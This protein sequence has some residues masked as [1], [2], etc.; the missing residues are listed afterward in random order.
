MTIEQNVLLGPLTTFH[1]GGPARYLARVST[2][3]EITEAF[4]YAQEAGLP[5]FVLGGGSNVLVSDN[6]FNGLV[7]M[8]DMR[9]VTVIN[10]DDKQVVLRVASG[11]IW[12]DVV[13]YA[14][15]RGLWGIENLSYLPGKAG[16]LAV[17]NV[18][19][20]GQEAS[21]VIDLVEVFDTDDKGL[22]ILPHDDCMFSYRASRF[23]QEDERRFIILSTVLKLSKIASPNLSYGDLQKYFNDSKLEP[24]LINI[25]EAIISIRENKYP[26]PKEPVNGSAGSF[27]KGPLLTDEEFSNLIEN[28]RQAF[29]DETA[30]R[31]DAMRDRLKVPQGFKT[32]GAFLL[33][34][35]GLK[36]MQMGGAKINEK[37]PAVILNA[38]GT[39]TSSDVI[40]LFEQARKIVFDKTGVMLESEPELV[41]FEE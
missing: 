13:K 7:M 29:G 1:I 24:T 40:G 18:G 20:Y 5:V 19:A 31:L 38:T 33:D 26:Y 27:F 6:G 12:D 8:P 32:P 35:C 16:A 14:V 39:A 11:E 9:G 34:I 37:Q 30:N 28:I 21:Q 25:R 17:Q 36:G 23:N 10:E 2:V 4:A 3:A 22:K 15:A 41:G